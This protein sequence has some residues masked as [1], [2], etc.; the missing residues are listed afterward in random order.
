MKR[1]LLIGV[2]AVAGLIIYAIVTATCSSNRL[3]FDFSQGAQGWEAD[4]AEY[5][6]EMEGMMLESGIR[7]L[8]SELGI[9]GAGYYLQG[10]NR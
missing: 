7:V 5:S 9:N 6:Q 4:F 3:E 10:M 1:N 8:P 2:V